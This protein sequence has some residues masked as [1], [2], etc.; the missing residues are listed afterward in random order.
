MDDPFQ[1]FQR[2]PLCV[3]NI[4]LKQCARAGGE[5]IIDFDPGSPEQPIPMF[6]WAEIPESYC[7]MASPEFYK[8]LLTQAS[9]AVSPGVG[10]VSTGRAV[11]ILL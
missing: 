5:D 10:L 3:F 11:C 4:D 1:C 6:V 7:D 8:K 9:V 2:L